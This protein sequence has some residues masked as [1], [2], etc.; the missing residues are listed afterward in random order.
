MIDRAIASLVEGVKY[1]PNDPKICQ[2]LARM[3]IDSRLFQ[4]A[5]EAL[6]S[7]PEESRQE[8][9][10]LELFGFCYEGLGR[11]DEAIAYSD[12]LLAIEPLSAPAMNIKGMVAYK[13]GDRLEAERFFQKASESDPGYG[14]PFTNLG[15]MQWADDKKALALD[16]LERGFLLSPT[17][18]DCVTLYHNAITSMEAFGRAEP[19]FREAKF[20]HP[21]NKRVFFLFIDVLLQQGKFNEAMEEVEEAMLTFDIDDGLIPAALQIREKVGVQQLPPPPVKR[22]T[23]SLCMIVKNEEAHLGKCLISVKDIA[24]EMIVVDTG[25]SD[26]TREIAAA[27]GARVFDFV[28]TDDFSE[29][30]N[31]SLAQAAGDWILVLDG[32]E[33]LSPD[34]HAALAKIVHRQAWQ[35]GCLCHRHP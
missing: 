34:D 3:L 25:S 26:K 20:L 14:E 9:K 18:T 12:H 19:V 16:L 4:D 23:L 27:F 17:C 30:R 33:T 29:A 10:S 21:K 32:D 31:Y 8:A 22:G 2:F 28:W 13:Q 35:A 11:T 15:V 1:A 5:L 7:M 24:D 6:T